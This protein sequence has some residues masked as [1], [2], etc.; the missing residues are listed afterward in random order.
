MKFLRTD[1]S[2]SARVFLVL[3][4]VILALAVYVRIPYLGIERLWPDEALYAWCAQR[5]F[6]QPQLVFSK[7]I[8]A[9][10]PPLF[11]LFLALGHFF[12]APEL[13]SRVMVMLLNILGIAGIYFLG[14]RLKSHFLGCFAALVMA[15][16]FLY[17]NQ[18]FFILTDG[19]LAVVLIFFFLVLT[20]VTPTPPCRKDV[21]AGLAACAVILTKW[22]GALVIPFLIAY[23]SLAFPQI[24]LRARLRKLAVPLGMAAG[25][26]ALLFLNNLIQL[27]HWMPDV[28]ALQGKYLTKPFWYYATGLK[29][30]FI[31]PFLIPF[32]ILGLWLMFRR[33]NRAFLSTAL[34]FGI[35]F[36]AISLT[37]EKDLRYS[38]P[39][40]PQLLLISGLGVE[41]ALRFLL[42]DEK[43]RFKAQIA[44]LIIIVGFFAMTYNRTAR[45]LGM[46]S[47]EFSGFRE[48]AYFVREE[49][50]FDSNPLV[51][52]ASPRTIRY[53]TG[54]NF[55]EFGGRLFDLPKSGEEL[56]VLT[57]R[58]NGPVILVLDAWERSNKE[59][60]LPLSDENVVFLEG[61][62]FK[63]IKEISRERRISKTATAHGPVVAVYRRD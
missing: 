7:E 47:R 1:L 34:W 63:K 62:K 41:E 52:A 59:W 5:I 38:L 35:F 17:L 32:F 30:I 60:A 44:V 26:T 23:Y 14:V 36:A 20:S 18:S 45:I 19:A 42:K 10:H 61:L 58:A 3:F 29:N 57:R 22:S 53:Y 12:F 2:F 48:A 39:V 56:T 43:F 6:H 15:F 55:A 31:V 37:P 4:C 40:F 49:T 16:N 28:S 51:I 24:P 54:I 46:I 27:G 50:A 33:E 9:F 25:V 8:I 21:F 11:P 13:A